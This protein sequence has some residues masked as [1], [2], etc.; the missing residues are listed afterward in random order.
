MLN[1]FEQRRAGIWTLA[2]QIGSR[3]RK[4]DQPAV[5]EAVAGLRGRSAP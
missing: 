3:K 1:L 2:E 5:R 4:G